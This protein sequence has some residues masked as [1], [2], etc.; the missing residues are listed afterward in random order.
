MLTTETKLMARIFAVVS[1]VSPLVEKARQSDPN[2]KAKIMAELDTA[3][4][5]LRADPGVVPTP[6]VDAF[7]IEMRRFA[8]ELLEPD[9]GRLI[10]VAAEAPPVASKPKTLR[11][12]FL[13]W[14]EAG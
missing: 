13:N 10:D 2:I 9:E 7:L 8:T 1:I 11:R 6:D 3:L 4:G 12:R 14:L 5:K